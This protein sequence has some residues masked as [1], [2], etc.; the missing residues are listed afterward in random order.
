MSKCEVKDGILEPCKLLHSSIEG[1]NPN[2]KKKGLFAW[3]TTSL[4]TGKQ[5]RSFAGCK[6]GE[7]TEQGIVFSYCPF[8]GESIAEH[9][10]FK[11]E[12]E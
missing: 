5:S 1:V 12:G 10:E 11:S 2:G 3:Q 7:Y 4:K 6:S 9:V 8:C